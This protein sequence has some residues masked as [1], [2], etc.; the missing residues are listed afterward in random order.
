M[1]TFILVAIRFPK[2][3]QFKINLI[4]NKHELYYLGHQ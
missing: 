4:K 2:F 1:K 3:D